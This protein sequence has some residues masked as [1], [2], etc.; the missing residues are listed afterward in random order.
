MRIHYIN[1]EVSDISFSPDEVTE[2]LKQIEK[3]VDYVA[4]YKDYIPYFVCKVSQ[5]N[6]IL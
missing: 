4:L 1:K 6:Y 5:I 2:I 3:G